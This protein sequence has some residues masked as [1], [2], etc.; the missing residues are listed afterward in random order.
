MTMNTNESTEC[1]IC[2]DLNDDQSIK[3][4]N[5]THIFHSHCLK[6]WL[7]EAPL[8][9]SCF[10]CPICRKFT[11]LHQVTSVSGVYQ[12]VYPFSFGLLIGFSVNV[13][14]RCGIRARVVDIVSGF[15]FS[16]SKILQ[17]MTLFGVLIR[18]QTS[19]NDILSFL[20]VNYICC[21]FIIFPFMNMFYLV[22]LDKRGIGYLSKKTIKTKEFVPWFCVGTMFGTIFGVK[23]SKFIC[24]LSDLTLSYF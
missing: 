10:S 17:Q 3:L 11:P 15:L 9:N 24:Y 2:L 8:E 23:L 16:G 20:M 1:A 21:P 18:T 19:A 22:Y 6:N 12:R 13:I 4:L 5:C 7:I 14:L